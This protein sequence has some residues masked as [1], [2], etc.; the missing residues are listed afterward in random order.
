[1]FM[2]F[3]H[4]NLLQNSLQPE[5]FY[6]V[7]ETGGLQEKN[8]NTEINLSRREKENLQAEHVLVLFTFLEMKSICVMT[9]NNL[10]RSTASLKVK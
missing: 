5:F 8:Q 1:M 3:F 4:L 2:S 10:Y 6:Q 9:I 7:T